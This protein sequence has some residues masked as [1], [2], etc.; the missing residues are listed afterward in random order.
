MRNSPI[1]PIHVLILV[2]AWLLLTAG[3]DAQ[4]STE[5]QQAQF[6]GDINHALPATGGGTLISDDDT[7]IMFD[8]T[9]GTAEGTGFLAGLDGADVDAY[10]DTDS[11]SA[12]VF[13]L[14]TTA[15]VNGTVMR[16]ADVFDSAG[17]KVL[18]AQAEGIADG[19]NVD[20]V[21]FDPA[22]CDLVFSVDIQAELGG[23]VFAPDDLIAWNSINGFSLFLAG[24][25]GADID[26]LHLLNL[27]NRVLFSTAV[28]VTLDGSL[29]QDEDIIEMIPD[30]AGRFFELSF[31]PSPFDLSWE[32]AGVDALWALR[33]PL[34][35]VFQWETAEIE[36]FEDAGSVSV[37]LVRTSGSEGSVD[38]NWGT[39]AGTATP[40][41]D[42][43]NTLDVLTLGDGVT[44]GSIMVNLLDDAD[45]EGT[46]TFN[47]RI[48]SVSDGSIGLPLVV[49]VIIRDDEDF[50][51]ADGFEN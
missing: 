11:C 2:C 31:S 32:P 6:S 20:A 40:G 16:P 30:G 5:L 38:I 36:V 33:A 47:I 21:S 23:T 39:S 35:G 1:K 51:F 48:I 45:V 13:S 46:E 22:T 9:T 18:D 44:S 4:T 15:E 24:N 28:D 37:M 34:P 27:E 10:H 17:A 26:A 43:T 25:L 42:F 50:V 8:L 19:V 49:Q 12:R 3:V 41:S 7:I 29:F 14:D